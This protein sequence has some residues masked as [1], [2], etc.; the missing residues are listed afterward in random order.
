MV[1]GGE[2]LINPAPRLV[3]TLTLENRKHQSREAWAESEFTVHLKSWNRRKLFM[4]S[5]FVSI[6]S[7]I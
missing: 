2:E 3:W 5:Q 1:E 7:L 4:C 6:F